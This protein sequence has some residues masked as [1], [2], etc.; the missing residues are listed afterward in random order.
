M[1]LII[2]YYRHIFIHRYLKSISNFY[3]FLIDENFFALFLIGYYPIIMYQRV[4]IRPKNNKNRIAPL[5]I[6]ITWWFHCVCFLSNV[7]YSQ[8]SIF[9]MRAHTTLFL[10]AYIFCYFVTFNDDFFKCYNM[11]Y[12]NISTTQINNQFRSNFR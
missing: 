4:V 9:S 1:D 7:Y 11:S 8:V 2:A 5:R 10:T 6:V 3:D 12:S